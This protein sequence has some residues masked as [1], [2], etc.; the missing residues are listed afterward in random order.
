MD[1]PGVTVEPIIGLDLVHE[2]NTVFFDNVRVPKANR[3]GE[4]NQGWTVAKYLLEFERGGVEYAPSI[5]FQLAKV[6]EIAAEA[7][8]YHGGRLID[9]DVFRR[10]ISA[11]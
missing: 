2:Q 10:K 8:T 9:D 11:T 7:K 5:H 4:E 6:K 3:I 1:A